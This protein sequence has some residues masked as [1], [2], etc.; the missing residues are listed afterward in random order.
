M[1]VKE[2]LHEIFVQLGK[3]LKIFKRKVKPM[4]EKASV[5]IIEL[6]TRHKNH[7]FEDIK[8]E[9]LNFDC[10][11][12]LGGDGTLSEGARLVSMLKLMNIVVHGLLHRSDWQSA[13]QVPIGVYILNGIRLI[14]INM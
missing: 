11:V 7:A 2:G 1:L 5:E 8:S 3:A 12:V 13:I 14:S 10:I 4:L 6:V 9:T